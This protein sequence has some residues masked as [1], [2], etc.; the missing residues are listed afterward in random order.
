MPAEHGSAHHSHQVA[1]CPGMGMDMGMGVEGQLES[2]AEDGRASRAYGTVAES[3]A[4]NGSAF[5]KTNQTGDGIW[6]PGPM[7]LAIS[8]QAE[9]GDVLAYLFRNWACALCLCLCRCD[10]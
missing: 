3:R 8:R 10:V 1:R 6:V 4:A 9:P 2:M 5:K 7:I